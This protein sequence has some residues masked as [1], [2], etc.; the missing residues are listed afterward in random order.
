MTRAG[1]PRLGEMK[2]AS[3]FTS[4]TFQPD[5]AKFGMQT[6]EPDTVALFARRAYDIAAAT[7]GVRVFLNGRRLPVSG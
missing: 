3:D 1:E 5:L 4:V 2:G 7:R 6:L